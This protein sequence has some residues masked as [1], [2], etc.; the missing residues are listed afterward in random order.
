VLVVML[1]LGLSMFDHSKMLESV[2]Y[3][4]AVCGDDNYLSLACHISRI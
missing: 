3:R 1:L 4:C 2:S